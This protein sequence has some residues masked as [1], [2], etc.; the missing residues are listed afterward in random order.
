MQKAY[1]TLR[2]LH[3]NPLDV[4]M[5][6]PTQIPASIVKNTIL[7][8]ISHRLLQRDRILLN[9]ARSYPVECGIVINIRPWEEISSLNVVRLYH[10]EKMRTDS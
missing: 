6:H 8:R 4:A 7:P 1:P 10:S 5:G 3:G 2:S 9:T